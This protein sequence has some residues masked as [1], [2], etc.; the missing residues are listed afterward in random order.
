M[1]PGFA[2]APRHE[3]SPGRLPAA[4]GLR[5]SQ[6]PAAVSV[7]DLASARA[8]PGAHRWVPGHPS[9][10]TSGSGSGSDGRGTGTEER[11]SEM[12][13]SSALT[14]SAAASSWPD[15]GQ[16]PV[17]PFV[18]P[19]EG[20]VGE[21]VRVRLGEVGRRSASIRSRVRRLRRSSRRFTAAAM[22]FGA[23]SISWTTR[24]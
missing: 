13:R 21:G 8:A 7:P 24:A 6:L 10:S 11:R 1:W 9:A 22:G 5:T 19:G 18:Q 23:A 15:I 20:F 12:A 3:V 4:Y 2:A 17:Y 16:Q 14:A